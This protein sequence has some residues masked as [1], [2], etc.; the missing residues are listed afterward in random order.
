MNK[1]IIMKNKP[2][3]LLIIILLFVGLGVYLVY[4][5]I[6]KFSN[7]QIPPTGVVNSF[8][9]CVGAG[10]PV[11]ESYPRQCQSGGKTFVEDIGN[12]L[13]KADLIYLDNPR[14]GQTISSPLVIS[15]QA[16]NTWFFEAS[17]PVLLTDWDGKIIAQGIAQAKSDWMTTE[18]VPFE[19]TL[20]FVVD[21][22]VYSNKGSLILRKDNPS[23][24]SIYDDALEIPVMFNI[25]TAG[26]VACDLMAKICPDGSA[27]GRTG[28]NCE[29][30]PCQQT[31]I[32]PYE[33]GIKGVVILGPTCPVERILPD[34]AC[35]FKGYKTTVQVIAVGSSSS[36]PFATIETNA[37]GEY[38]V[39]LPPGQYAL[40]PVGGKT[41]PRC[42]TREVTVVGNIIQEVTLT[43]DTG[44]R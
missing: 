20:S 21:K 33:S 8:E 38:S 12:V 22:N 44:I 36:A 29:F 14:P 6:N 3:V 18:F 32:L 15:G 2:I 42:E 13:Q 16:H 5:N 35:V 34:P 19:A 41:F 37:S 40:Q 7:Q 31:S 23:G 1:K 4:L 27:V 11:M 39:S 26:P 25:D 10:N 43:C 28:P 17:F 30:A 9:E 24:L